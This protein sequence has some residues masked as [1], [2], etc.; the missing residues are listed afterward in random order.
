MAEFIAFNRLLEDAAPLSLA[1]Q[2]PGPGGGFYVLDGVRVGELQV[3][4]AT[5]AREEIG[6][7]ATSLLAQSTCDLDA[8]QICHG[9]LH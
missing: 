9:D 2:G 1:I 6:L 8:E 3:I 7:D 5:L 4:Q